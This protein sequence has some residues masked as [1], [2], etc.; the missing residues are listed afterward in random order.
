[1]LKNN[2]KSNINNKKSIESKHMKFILLF[3]SL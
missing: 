1:M 3:F 2:N